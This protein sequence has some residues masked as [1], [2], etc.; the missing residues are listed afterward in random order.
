MFFEAHVKN[1]LIFYLLCKKFHVLKWQIKEEKTVWVIVCVRFEGTL[2]Q[3]NKMPFL[4]G[5]FL[6]SEIYLTV[7]KG[8][9]RKREEV[10]GDYLLRVNFF[11]R[12]ANNWQQQ[13]F[14]LSWRHFQTDRLTDR[15]KQI[16]YFIKAW[17]GRCCTILNLEP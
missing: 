17:K 10:N 13:F 4:A 5:G 2:C 12:F 9:K 16:R 11:S 14:C 7:Q 3:S 8:H 6:M 15:Q 1:L